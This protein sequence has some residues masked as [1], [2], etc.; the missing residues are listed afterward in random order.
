MEAAA[1]RRET[2]RKLQQLEATRQLLA[3]LDQELAQLSPADKLIYQK[4]IL[5]PEKGNPALLAEL[6]ELERPTLYRHRDKLLRT[7]S[8]LL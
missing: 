2:M 7:L 5:Y 8:T 6:L 3:R 4:L 1:L